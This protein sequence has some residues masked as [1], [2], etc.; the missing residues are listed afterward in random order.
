MMKTV[1]KLIGLILAVCM[2]AA[3]AAGCGSSGTTE[4]K[5]EAAKAP[6]ATDT[7]PSA[8]SQDAA[9]PEKAAE[10]PQ[11]ETDPVVPA[12]E[13]PTQD[14]PA[15]SPEPAPSEEPAPSAPAS[16]TISDEVIV[17]DENC[18]F[19]IVK[20]ED[21][22]LWGFTL[23]AF[24]ENKTADKTL[25]FSIDDVSVNG[26]M[27]DP[28][29][30]TEVAAGK[31]S[32]DEITFLTSSFETIGITTADEITFTLNVYDYDDWM[33][34][35]LV[36]DTFTIYPTGLSKD[37]VVVPERKTTAGEETI[38]DDGN[39]SFIILETD[40]DNIWGYTL[41]CYLENKTDKPLMF[42]WDDVSVNGFMVD[43]FWASEVAPGMRSYAQ[44]SFMGSEFDDNG[45][46][47]V[48]EIEFLLRI[49]D[50]D[51]WMADNLYESVHTYTP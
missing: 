49:S 42:S 6:E 43:P 29:W 38:L 5:E 34:D 10:E 7:T 11:E 50:A 13:E 17:D 39:A 24:C 51:D 19:K 35:Y 31:K 4:P 26:Y 16:Y 1:Y 12:E 23:K 33:A 15:P 41:L 48:E 28:V 20:A 2:I 22:A 30:A 45:I 8:P 27:S 44:I 21:D 25:M 46:T 3:F 18:T 36:S 9:E 32:N 37:Q 40:P 47:D 14:E